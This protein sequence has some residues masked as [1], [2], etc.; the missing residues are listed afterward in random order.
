MN[1]FK[2]PWA[3]FK[4]HVDAH[5]LR[6]QE[7]STT[8]GYTLTAYNGP[9]GFTCYIVKD[10]GADQ[11]AYETNYQSAANTT[12]DPRDSDGSIINKT[13]TTRTGWHYE[14]RSLDFRTSKRASLYNRSYDGNTIADGTDLGDATIKF[15]DDSGAELVQ[16]GG[17]SDGDYQ[18]RLTGNCV[19]TQIDWQPDHDIDIIG[20]AFILENK[21]SSDTYA[22]LTIAPDLPQNLGG[23]V[24]HFQGG[25]NLSFFDAG[26]LIQFDGRGSKT[27]LYDPVYNSNVFRYLVKHPVGEQIGIQLIYDLFR[28]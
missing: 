26:K 2:L 5:S 1:A 24:P 16:G 19:R 21:P 11:T 10:G 15:F 8:H 20:G 27:V 23:P 6:I 14:P 3:D 17:E 4:S 12:L 18:T 22:W 7:Q 9:Q 13:K 25:F 28:G